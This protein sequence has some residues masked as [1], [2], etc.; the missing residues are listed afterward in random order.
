MFFDKRGLIIHTDTNQVVE[1]TADTTVVDVV[2]DDTDGEENG[3]SLEN[4][5]MEDIIVEN[6]D[7]IFVE[8]IK[9][10]LTLAQ[11]NYNTQVIYHIKE[12][13]CKAINCVIKKFVNDPSERMNFWLLNLIQQ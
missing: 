10:N 2:P 12:E 8:E 4:V 9:N 6:I 11:R 5:N 1:N 13:D 3:F 7:L